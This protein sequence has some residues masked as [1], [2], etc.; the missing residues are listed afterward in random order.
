[1]KPEERSMILDLFDRIAAAPKDNID[2]EADQVI[3]D[4]VTRNPSAPLSSSKPS[5]SR[6]R[7]YDVP[8]SA[9]AS[10]RMPRRLRAPTGK[11]ASW[12]PVAGSE[13]AQFRTQGS[14]RVRLPIRAAA[15]TI[16]VTRS[17][18]RDSPCRRSPC[19]PRPLAAVAF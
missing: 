1:M 4:A 15:P 10:F 6:R 18:C 17:Q 9:S 7:R 11:L 2:R 5:S 8:M 3:R 13:A 16:P 12:A 14:G 19:S